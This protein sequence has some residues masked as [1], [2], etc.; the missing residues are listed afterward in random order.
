MC[1]LHHWQNHGLPSL[2]WMPSSSKGHTNV[3][4]QGTR[5][6]MSFLWWLPVKCVSLFSI[7]FNSFCY[8]WITIR[9]I[10]FNY[11]FFHHRPTHELCFLFCRPFVINGTFSTGLVVYLLAWAFDNWSSNH[12]WNNRWFKLQLSTVQARRQKNL[13]DLLKMS[14]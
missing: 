10:Y 5:E 6:M 13:Q 4:V 11:L 9:I 3:D 7:L 14:H 2:A 1:A 8:R 12:N